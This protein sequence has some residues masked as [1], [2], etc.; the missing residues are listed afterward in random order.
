MTINQLFSQ[1][2]QL[3]IK[4]WCEG[5]SLRY[6]A[7]PGALTD[8]LR[9]LLKENKSDILSF[10][11]QAKLLSSSDQ[12]GTSNGD[13]KKR[14]S[15]YSPF[16]LINPDFEQRHQP[17]PFHDIQQ[18]Y[19][20]GRTPNFEFSIPSHS[21][22]EFEGKNIDPKR[23]S[24]AWQEV[25]KRHEMLRAVMLPNGQQKIISEVPDYEI[26][27]IDLRGQS[28]QEIETENEEI[29][30]EMA[31]QRFQTDQW[32]LF[33]LRTVLIDQERV[34]IHI[35]FDLLLFDG[36]STGILL[37]EWATFYDNPHIQ[38]EPLTLSFRDYVLAKR[39]LQQS[40][41]YQQDMAYWQKRIETLPPAPEIPLVQSS[42]SKINHKFVRLSKRLTPETWQKLKLGIKKAGLTQSSTLCTVYAQIL[43]TWS[44]KSHF[45]IN[46][47]HFNRLPLHSQVNK[48]VGNF[49]STVLLEVD[50][51]QAD[52]FVGRAK[53]L[54][55]QLGKDLQHSLVSGVDI[56]RE[57][58]RQQGKISR[59]T[60]PFT[61]ASV[62]DNTPARGNTLPGFLPLDQIEG[63]LQVPQVL[64]D[65][66]LYEDTH[67]ALIINWDFVKAAFPQGLVEEMFEAYLALLE[68]LALDSQ[69]WQQD[70]FDLRSTQ[71]KIQQQEVNQTDAI[72]S[73]K[74][75][76]ELFLEQVKQ[77]PDQFAVIST[78]QKFTYEQLY[79]KATQI[80]YQ[81]R[82]W[83]VQPNQLVAVVMRKGW[84][85]VVAVLAILM[86]GAAYVPIDA[87]L[88]EE[89]RY[90][91]LQQSEAKFILTQSCLGC[92]I[93]VQK[94]LEVD[95]FNETPQT[96]EPLESLQTP[97]DLAY[98][99]FTSGSTGFPKGVMIDHQGAVNTILDINQRFK[100]TNKDK[101][102]ALSSLSFDLSVYD[103]FGV[104][105][106][107][108]TII[109]PDADKTKEPSHWLQ[110]LELYKVT[111][112]NSVPALMQL[113]VEEANFSDDFSLFLRLVMLSGDWIPLNLPTQI[114]DLIK[115]IEVI[116]LG[117][118]T[119]ASIWSILY[120]IQT[121]SPD[122]SSIPYGKPMTNQRFYVLNDKFEPCPTWVTGQLYI[123]GVG[124]AKGY[125][126]DPEKTSFRWV[127]NPHTGEKLYKTGDL[128]RYLPDGNIEF[129]GRED[130]QVK[131]QGYR[132]ECGEIETLLLEH[133]Q[134]KSGIVTVTGKP[135]EEKHLVAYFCPN[136]DSIPSAQELKDFLTKKL[137]QYMVP[138]IFVPLDRLPL[139]HNGKVDRKA[140]PEPELS[141]SFSHTNFTAPRNPLE[142]EMAQIWSE[143]L[144]ISTIS[145]KDNFFELGG[146][147]LSA[148]RLISRIQHQMGSD[149]HLATLLEYSSI[150]Q[151]V[152]LVRQ[153]S[154][155][156]DFSPLV[157]I[158]GQGTEKPLFLIHP[159]GG[160]VLCYL[161]LAQQLDTNRPV[162]G[163]Q[164]IGITGE[165]SPL[166]QIEEMATRYIQ[167]IRTI[168]PDGDYHL[169]GWSLGGIIAFEMAQQLTAMG[170]KVSFLGL[171]DSYIPNVSHNKVMF[172][173]ANLVAAVAQ[174]LGAIAHQDLGIS[175]EHL[176]SL[177]PEEQLD[178]VL[179]Q[180]KL[181]NVFPA[182]INS[183]Q[184]RQL[185]AIFKA[186][187]YAM[188][189]YQPK[190]YQGDIHLWWANET[191]VRQSEKGLQEHDWNKLTT[192]ALT[193]YTLQGNHY[194]IL[195]EPQLS[196]LVKQFQAIL[197]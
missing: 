20:M 146:T 12:E 135:Q 106:A 76:H 85:Q 96:L 185:L 175:L 59:A 92:L 129:Q 58:N 55:K 104:L 69:I 182:E 23:L 33:D 156:Q 98:V 16:P 190:P 119:E 196:I 57:I 114:Q 128:G 191:K 188:Y 47:L 10:L 143:I 94:C 127:N 120:P 70:S 22:V 102:L 183:Q 149:I 93:H 44:K 2:R 1:L 15:G 177:A 5:E 192:G 65:H 36:L 179:E 163:L 99:I 87:D 14:Q 193:Q 134:I 62:L 133:P 152:P 9:M 170:Q 25:V 19:W 41:K 27:V 169:G 91:L 84:E 164:S 74:C 158:Q 150:E 140:L 159:V 50:H 155:T 61:F 49:S 174:D 180:A 124:L 154:Q 121:V 8:E 40:A 125:W 90:Q 110:L 101:V 138:S 173:D 162:Y 48:L 72:V 71:Q 88:P 107:G 142:L 39:E 80:A 66:Q 157:T 118:A 43:S 148:M 100:V 24:K 83:G 167:A 6:S 151:L 130:F 132:I 35:S 82:H 197:V 144:N 75:L 105:A 17:F 171:I 32:P 141:E 38:L 115:D 160:N 117:G 122:W 166:D 45:C 178:L 3:D 64:L 86:A 136:G 109:L 26:K 51:R 63:S 67:G 46:L 116:G 13:D 186:N 7:P 97:H 139:S 161:N 56:V 79:Q 123:A 30:Q 195:D 112:W 103:I 54:Q 153:H 184:M 168:Q 18:A 181:H 126:K 78:E 95:T 21:Y 4:L 131:V 145:V 187:N 137:P 34:R 29:G 189:R 53:R 77:Q 81:L 165:Q 147:S 172:E 73:E 68:N 28:A 176:R 194:T 60:M 42:T 37:T 111:L 31:H 108:G 52:S 11:Q 89:R 113:L